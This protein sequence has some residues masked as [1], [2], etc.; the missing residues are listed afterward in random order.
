MKTNG[1]GVN[2][3]ITGNLTTKKLSD[4]WEN[5]NVIVHGK[6]RA[7][8]ISTT[9][10]ILLYGDVEFQSADIGGLGL[11]YINNPKGI[12]FVIDSV[13]GQVDNIDPNQIQ[14]FWDSEF[15]FDYI[16]D[17]SKIFKKEYFD[18]DFITF[19]EYK[20]ENDEDDDSYSDYVDE[21]DIVNCL[22]G[23]CEAMEKGEDVFLK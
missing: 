23:I 18:D 12:L 6:T 22:Y 10:N 21:Y 17:V 4:I 2:L 13:N 16:G 11:K 3:V 19:E 5:D 7:E 20:E 14:I 9:G 15:N 1:K 8:H